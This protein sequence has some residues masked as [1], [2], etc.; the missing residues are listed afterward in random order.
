M[1]EKKPYYRKRKGSVKTKPSE[2][3]TNATSLDATSSTTPASDLGVAGT[4][5][6]SKPKKKRY[7]RKPKSR[8]ASEAEA[9]AVTQQSIADTDSDNAKFHDAVT[10]TVLNHTAD[11]TIDWRDAV[12]STAAER[13]IDQMGLPALPKETVPA[14]DAK[15]KNS[16]AVKDA[17]MHHNYIM[18]DKLRYNS[19]SDNNTDEETKRYM[20]KSD[21]MLREHK[22][23][24]ALALVAVFLAS[25]CVLSVWYM[26]MK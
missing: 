13:G 1:S 26:L 21:L 12:R 24:S 10:A 14:E 15:S 17:M 4:A 2:V 19:Y 5:Q 18:H 9:W 8:L 22:L 6:T 25:V 16:N 11:N 3:E 23:I 7:N 20:S